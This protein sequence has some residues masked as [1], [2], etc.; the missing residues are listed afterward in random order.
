VPKSKSKRS[1]Y[2][3]PP[4]PKPKPSPRWVPWVGLGLI[5]VGLLVVLLT[6]LVPGFPGGNYNLIGGFV[7]MAIGL[8]VLS[9]WR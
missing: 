9:T 1:T 3:P 4:K 2:K 6:Y 5:L 8:F 7:V